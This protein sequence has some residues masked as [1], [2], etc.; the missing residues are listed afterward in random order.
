MSALSGTGNRL[1][2]LQHAK[3]ESMVMGPLQPQIVCRLFQKQLLVE[4]RE[5]QSGRPLSASYLLWEGT[6]IGQ[7]CS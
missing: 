6:G 7:C 2:C 1:P 4:V 3:R 5:V